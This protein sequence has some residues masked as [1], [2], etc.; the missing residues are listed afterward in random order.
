MDATHEPQRTKT[1]RALSAAVAA[2]MAVQSAAGLVFPG[3]Y[4]DADWIRA[5]WFG[6]D[7]VT[8]FVA[9]PLLA[10]ALVLVR[11]GSRRAELVWYSVL[12]YSAYNYA[13]YLFGGRMNVLF[14]L[15]AALFVLPVLTLALALSRADVRALAAGFRGSTPVRW[16]SAYMLLT[17]CGLAIAWLAQWA[18]FVFGGI[19]P[20][21]G[22]EA[23]GLIAAMDLTFMVPYFVLGGVLLWRRRPWGYLLGAVMILKGATYTPVL[24]LGSVVGALRGV[25]GSAEQIPIWGVWTVVGAAAIAALLRHL[26]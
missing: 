7:L 20:A 9:A 1:L 4:R 5:A 13:F 8:L 23:F 26:R 3:L 15:L 10:A 16:I 22:E 25:E 24:T 21:I 18:A 19:E 12:G 17:G 6:N 11:R 14:P 2:L